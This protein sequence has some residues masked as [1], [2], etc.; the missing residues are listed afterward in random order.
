VLIAGS[1][2]AT[3][4][5][6]AVGGLDVLPIGAGQPVVVQAFLA[7]GVLWLLRSMATRGMLAGR[8]AAWVGD[9]PWLPWRSV[10]GPGVAAGLAVFVLFLP[11][12]GVTHRLVPTPPRLALWAIVAVLLLPFFAAFE[13]L[14]R[15][16]ATWRA[17]GGG[18]LGRAVLL[19]ALV[20]G[21]A[22]GVLPSVIGIVL[23]LL[24]GLYL[25][26]EIFAAPCYAR[27]RNPAVVAV[28]ES[29]I[30]AWAAITLTPVG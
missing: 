8:L 11:L 17:V 13:S 2:A 15:R 19:A 16:G 6:M 4:P 3:A 10:A 23:P 24:A 12:A 1:L 9:R 22:A 14:V 30:I 21:L 25:I 5:V 28:A 7:G 18:L 26:V 29:V 20:L 27:A